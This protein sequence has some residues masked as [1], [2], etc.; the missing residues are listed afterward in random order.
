MGLHG[1]CFV[2]LN[3]G[4]GELK[5]VDIVTWLTRTYSIHSVTHTKT[6]V[7]SGMNCICSIRVWLSNI[8]R[9]SGTTALLQMTICPR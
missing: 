1:R 5:G 9:D 6:Y 7:L 8:L 2:L 4:I 3:I